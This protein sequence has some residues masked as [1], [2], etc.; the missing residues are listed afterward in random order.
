MDADAS[1]VTFQLIGQVCSPDFP[2]WM[3]RH[4]RKL[5]VVFE[6]TEASSGMMTVKAEGE[7]EMLEAFALAC[8][9]GPKSVCVHSL[10][11][12]GT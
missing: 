3:E 12:A 2:E 6:I 11:M 10:N 7:D 5:D 4:A 9:L 1:H 8:S